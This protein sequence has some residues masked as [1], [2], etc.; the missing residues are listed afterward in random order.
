[1]PFLLV[2]G[3][4][5]TAAVLGGALALGLRHGID[6]DHIAAITDITSTAA[7]TPTTAGLD[8]L[9]SEP[10]VLLS[11][12]SQHGLSLQT[13]A[14]GGTVAATAT[15]QW[16]RSGVRTHHWTRPVK[17]NRRPLLLGT[18]YA[19]GHGSM[20]I[21]LGLLAIVFAGIL[22]GWVDPVMERVVGVT[23][24]FLAAFLFYSLFR[25]FRGGG[26]FRIR[27]R[28]MLVFSLVGAVTHRVGDKLAGRHHHHHAPDTDQQ[29]G[30]A[31][32][33]SVGLIHGIGA[34]TGTQVLI[35][36]TAVGADSKGMAIATLFVFVAGLLISNSVVTL[37]TVFG[38]VSAQRQRWVYVGV[39][40][41]AAVFSLVVGIL[42]LFEAG[43]SLPNLDQYFSWIG[44]PS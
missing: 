3:V 30:A 5:G 8:L 26:E 24:I 15:A 12:E 7:S 28:W 33:Y 19:L 2:F 21:V 6:W 32:A 22:P 27:S 10:G 40:V 14:V 16:S 34:E 35:I 29:Y 9:T 36:G 43:G 4:G 41:F 42:F 25:H 23:L 31:T 20:V 37:A 11:D 44:G 18:L 38:F 1:V 39:G 13:A 17:E